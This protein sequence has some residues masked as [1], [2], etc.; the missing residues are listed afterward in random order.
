MPTD[1]RLTPPQSQN[2]MRSIPGYSG[3]EDPRRTQNTPVPGA[4]NNDP[5][6]IPGYVGPDDPR[7]QDMSQG[8]GFHIPANKEEF[9]KLSPEQQQQAGIEIGKMLG[10]AIGSNPKLLA[11]AQKMGVGQADQQN[12]EGMPGQTAQVGQVPVT[13]QPIMGQDAQANTQGLVT[14]AV[15]LGGDKIKGLLSKIGVGGM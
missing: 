5:R 11:A 10:I 1:P 12:P 13:G 3:Q 6:L 4:V 8:G 2:D 9:S 15:E 14:K 7:R